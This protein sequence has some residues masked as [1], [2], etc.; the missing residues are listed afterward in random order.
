MILKA[1]WPIGLLA[2]A[3][4][5]GNK[6]SESSGYGEDPNLSTAIYESYH[7]GFDL[8]AP[9]TNEALDV[10]KGQSGGLRE[11]REIADE[12]E[13]IAGDSQA[14]R[15]E[16][17]PVSNSYRLTM[18]ATL[19]VNLDSGLQILSLHSLPNEGLREDV[20]TY[21]SQKVDQAD[22]QNIFASL[23]I[24]RSLKPFDNHLEL[25]K[26]E[27]A[28]YVFRLE[29]DEAS[30]GRFGLRDPFAAPQHRPVD[31][32]AFN[33]LSDLYSGRLS[34]DQIPDGQF[35]KNIGDLTYSVTVTPRLNDLGQIVVEVYVREVNSL[36]SMS[37]ALV[38]E[39]AEIGLTQTAS[40]VK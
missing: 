20:V 13:F 30:S 6:V 38:Y 27:L 1:A 11:T 32:D 34:L 40:T 31:S 29:S 4:T 17:V 12:F 5:V 10:L 8:N 22:E 15:L 16:Q 26:Q 19:L 3:I 9:T 33:P 7:A 35:E 23:V 24:P 36:V 25:Q 2:L 37:Y 39:D 18:V 21:F 28:Q 14:I